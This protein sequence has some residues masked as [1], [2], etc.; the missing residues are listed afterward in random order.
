M[1][2]VSDEV[3]CPQCGYEKAYYEIDCRS[4]E[5]EILCTRCGYRESWEA[6]NDEDGHA[7]HRKISKLLQHAEQARRG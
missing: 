7:A 6:K 5:E 4:S 1:S 2:T 3:K